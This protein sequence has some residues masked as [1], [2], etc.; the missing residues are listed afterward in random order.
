MFTIIKIQNMLSLPDEMFL[1]MSGKMNDRRKI[2]LSMT[3]RQLNKMK[4]KMIYSKM[5]KIKKA[6]QLPYFDNFSN[7]FISDRITMLPKH[8]TNLTFGDKFNRSIKDCIPTSVTHVR[9]GWHFDQ[10]IKD[11]IPLSVTH[12]IFGFK[13]NQPIKDCIPPSVT[14][15]TFGEYFNQ[16]IKD[17][18]PISV[19]HLT[20]GKGF[21]QPISDMPRTLK[22]ITLPKHGKQ[23][24]KNDIS[25]KIN[26]KWAR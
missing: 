13:F 2:R 26:I 18:I 16:S 19:T 25:K 11:C 4:Y 23:R 14:H 24:E 22:E 1:M 17:C 7:I 12:L 8:I 21:D 10:P 6:A 9:F 20:L 15:L 3:C 5:M